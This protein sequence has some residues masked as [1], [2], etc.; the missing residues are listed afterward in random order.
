MTSKTAAW[1]ARSAVVAAVAAALVQG[2]VAETVFKAEFREGLPGWK[3]ENGNTVVAVERTFGEA[4]FVVRRDPMAKSKGTNWGVTSGQFAVVPGRRLSIIV[5]ARSTY[6]DLRFCHGFFGKYITGV[7]WFD[8]NGRK[9]SIPYGFG[10]D[11]KKGDWC[12]TVASTVVPDGA[13][14][15]RLEFGMDTPNF[16]TN[17]WFAVSQARVEMFDPKESGSVVSLRDDGAVL[18]DGKPFFPIGIYAVCECE[19][20][21]NSIDTAFR[22]LKDAGFN[23]ML[24]GRAKATNEEFLSLADRHGLKVIQMPAP[25]YNSDFVKETLV[26]SLRHHKSVLAWYLADDTA[27]H[28]GPEEVAYRDRVCKAFDPARL[29]LQ[30]D[31]VAMGG[32]NCRYDRFVHSTD[33]FLPEIY[34]AYHE[35][36]S[37][38]EVS[39]VVRDMKLSRTAVAAAGSP[40]KS[41]WP[42]IQHFDGWSWKRFPTFEE[43]RAM[44][45]VSIVQGG[46]GIVWYVYHSKSGKGRGVVCSD[47]HWKEMTTVSSEIASLQDDLLT[48][49]AAEQPA[50]EVVSGPSK[51]YY[52]YPSVNALLKTGDTPLLA[53]VNATTNAVKA[54]IRV[55]GF[56]QAESVGK[57][58][59]LGATKGISDEWEPYG[60]RLYRLSR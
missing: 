39:D 37:G 45:W 27:S 16:S 12:Y 18:V 6:E 28:V 34:P 51:D 38:H 54:V 52:G 40:V 10:Y 60:V 50:V 7:N 25:S 58:R 24:R 53:T 5:R 23:T 48:R 43:L 17:D 49:N 26:P 22:D 29:T 36:P 33:V 35:K 31:A 4:A 41:I 21:G 32:V 59:T 30:A 46:K 14:K 19:R 2:A 8:G 11:L 9:I 57:G 20:N 47:E 42:I 56:R 44:S 3:V 55:K 13:V 15:A 1:M